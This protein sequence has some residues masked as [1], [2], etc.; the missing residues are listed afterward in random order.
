MFPDQP[1]WWRAGA[2]ACHWC[3]RGGLEA[4]ANLNGGELDERPILPDGEPG[5]RCVMRMISGNREGKT[6]KEAE[7]E[8]EERPRT[9]LNGGDL[10][11][12]TFVVLT[13]ALPLWAP[14]CLPLSLPLFLS[15]CPS[16]G[17]KSF[18]VCG[19]TVKKGVSWAGVESS[20]LEPLAGPLPVPMRGFACHWS[21]LKASIDCARR[22]SRGWRTP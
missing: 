16:L 20:A 13:F 5:A 10:V 19:A 1:K 6:S 9:N 14:L 8:I 21:S 11:Q 12:S 17:A 15:F 4:R 2:R 3:I 7:E 22:G 18:P